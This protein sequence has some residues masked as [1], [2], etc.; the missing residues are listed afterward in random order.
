VIFGYGL[1]RVVEMLGAG[2]IHDNQHGYRVEI[3][4]FDQLTNETHI[5]DV[6]LPHVT[7]I[8]DLQFFIDYEGKNFA[9]NLNK[10]LA[11]CLLVLRA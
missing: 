8:F 9:A 2:Q 6:Y 7:N 11:M 10:R 5:G 4:T 1:T 3:F